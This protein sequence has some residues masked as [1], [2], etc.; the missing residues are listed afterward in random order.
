MVS[1]ANANAGVGIN[2][3]GR[4]LATVIQKR[5]CRLVLRNLFILSCLTLYITHFEILPSS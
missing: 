2:D 5:V 1:N 4:V 3:L